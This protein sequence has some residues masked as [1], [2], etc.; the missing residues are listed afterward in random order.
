MSNKCVTNRT[1]FEFLE[2]NTSQ[3]YRFVWL[4][5]GWIRCYVNKYLLLDQMELGK[6]SI[7]YP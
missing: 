6:F 5:T 4:Y 7:K 1:M 2:Q 3:K